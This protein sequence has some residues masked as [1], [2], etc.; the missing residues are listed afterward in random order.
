MR[1]FLDKFKYHGLFI[2]MFTVT[3]VSIIAVSLLTSTVM[4]QMSEKLFMNTFSITNSKIISQIKA[5][6]ESFNYS[7][8]TASNNVLQNGSIKVSSQ[9]RIKTLL[10]RLAVIM[11]PVCK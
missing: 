9:S 6:F 3:L 11:R 4:I 2:K 7:I 8:V 5:N 1:V 10:R